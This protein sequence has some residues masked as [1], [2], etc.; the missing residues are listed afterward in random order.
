MAQDVLI[1]VAGM[2]NV[3]VRARAVVSERSLSWLSLIAVVA[4]SFGLNSWELSGNGYGNTFYAAA[5]RSMSM[6]WKNFFF[7]SFDP[8]GFITVDKP[9]VF[10]WVDALSVRVFGYSSWSLLLPSAVAG[11]AT[12]ALVWLIVRRYFGTFA[13]TL[14]AL[15]LALTPITVAV[16][17]LNLPEP[18]YVLALVGAAY[19]ILR[20]LES[21]RWWAWVATAGVLVGIAF[22]T[23]MLAAWIPGPAMALAMVVGY[24]GAWRWRPLVRNLLPRLA[25]LAAATLVVSVSWMV[26]VDA[27]PASQRPYIGGSTDNTVSNLALGYNGFGRVDGNEQAGRG[28]GALREGRVHPRTATTSPIAA[29]AV[30]RTAAGTTAFSEVAARADLVGALAVTPARYRLRGRARRGPVASSLAR[31]GCCA[32]STMPTATRLRGSFRS[33]CLAAILCLWYWRKDRVR[34]AAT[35]LFAGWVLL[36]A[37]IFSSA[38]GIYHSY[39]T[40][41]LAPGIAVLV[42]MSV[43]AAIGLAKKNPRWLV[44]F[45]PVVGTTIWVQLVVTGRFPGFRTELRPLAAGVVVAGA[46]LAFG[47][48]IRRKV[49]LAAGMAVMAAGL[50]ILPASWTTYEATHASLNTTLPQAG[51]RQGAAGNSFGSAAFDDGTASLAAWLEAHHDPNSRWDLAVTSAQNASTLIAQYQLSVM[52]LGG[53]L[54]TDPTITVAQFAEL[55]AKGE[56]RYV[57][58]SGGGPGGFGGRGGFGARGGFGFIPNSGSIPG[59]GLGQS[60]TTTSAAKGAAVV[61]SAVE[62]SCTAVTGSDVPAQYQGSLYDC[63]GKADALQGTAG[64]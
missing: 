25:L 8:G 55:V 22:N 7:G 49:P 50:L 20:S 18:F 54:G 57:L 46:A 59:L 58:T 40:S 9:P 14:A 35:V 43:I 2:R 26:V 51:P 64:Q 48:V 23:K 44:A 39:Y 52:A 32:C 6:S 38:Q 41:A 31:R 10:L 29:L 47:F 27:W 33:L 60:T 1:P 28:G 5:V 3:G 45:I 63:S 19:A 56:V 62:Q 36:F 24:R 17:R 16:D 11:A 15:V 37:Y 21:R 42:G 13:A 4:V 30:P 12:V 61:M 34:R 53:F